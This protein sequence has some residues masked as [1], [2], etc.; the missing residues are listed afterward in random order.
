MK[1]VVTGGAGF[2]GGKLIQSLLEKGTLTDTAGTPQTITGI[3]SLDRVATTATDDPR[4][5]SMIGSV[6]D[7]DC[8]DSLIAGDVASVFH[9]AAVVSAGAETDFDLGYAVNLDGTRH[10]LEACRRLSAPPKLVFASSIAVYG[11][12]LP[13]VIDDTTE[14]LPQLSYGIQKLIGEK[15]VADYTRKGFIDGRALRLPTVMVRTGKPNPAA[16]TWASSII[17]EPLS[18]QD[19]VCPVTPESYM[20]CLSARRTIDSFIHMHDL[21]SAALGLQRSVQLPGIPVTAEEMVAAAGRNAGNRALGRVIW[22]QDAATQAI[23]DGW[24]RETRSARAAA[25]GFQADRD[26]DAIVRNFIADDLDMQIRNFA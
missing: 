25:L 10:V 23:V 6:A 4:V 21:T 24:P 22:Q 17:R 26:I 3:V 20:A 18:G 16:S 14:P 15:L 8:V 12:G 2:L 11:G 7:Q 5:T 19:V 13:P 9:L 1:I